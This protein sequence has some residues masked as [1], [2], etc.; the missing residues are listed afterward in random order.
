MKRRVERAVLVI[1]ALALVVF[2]LPVLADSQAR[3]VRLSYLD[4]SVEI[5]RNAGDGFERAIVNMPISQG[6][7]LTTHEDGEAEV[8]FEDGSTLRLAP[9]TRVSFDEL[10]LRSDGGK[11]TVVNVQDGT[12]YFNVKHSDKDDFR[13]L[14]AGQDVKLAKTSHFRAEVRDRKVD[15]AVF[16]GELEL[17]GVDGQKRIKKDETLTLNLDA[18][19]EYQLAKGVDQGRFDWW[20]KERDQYQTQYSYRSNGTYASAA[21]GGPYYGWSDLNYYGSMFYLPGY[22]YVWR[23]YNVDYGWDPFGMGYWMYYPTW[24]YTWVSP[25]AW[26]WTPYRYGNWLFAAGYGWV[27]QPTPGG[28]GTWY[29]RPRYTNPPTTYRPPTPPTNYP[30]RPIPGRPVITVGN[31][32]GTNIP[33]WTPRYQPPNRPTGIL[34]RDGAPDTVKPG[35]S[36]EQGNRKVVTG[37]APANGSHARPVPRSVPMDRNAGSTSRPAPSRGMEGTRGTEAPRSAPSMPRSTGPSFSAPRYAPMGGGSTGGG[38]RAPSVSTPR[39]PK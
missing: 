16:K 28:Y 31:P 6:A 25:Y 4:G 3:I 23:P 19:A 13:V 29:P 38:T 12:T 7:R 21:Y 32:S 27:W 5:D 10:A 14:F 26:G 20:D 18:P 11:V 8:E 15:V 34:V 35:S 22:G 39:N 1:A 36:P 37:T 24:G 33:R 2:A 30:T 17:Q 9:D